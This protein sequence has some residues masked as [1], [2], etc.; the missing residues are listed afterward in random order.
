MNDRPDF[1]RRL[2][3]AFASYAERAP[4][5]VDA[6]ILTAVVARGPGHRRWSI[7]R[8]S[9]LLVAVGVAVSLILL[10]TIASL[11][12]GH[13]RLVDTP[14]ASP[15]A[16]AVVALASPTAGPTRPL[17][18]VVSNGLIAYSTDGVPPGATDWSTGSDVYVVA[19][20]SQPTLV[21]SREGGTF[22]NMCPTFSP[23]GTRLA[24]AR[25][26]SASSAI[27]VVDVDT[28]GAISGSRE[29]AVSQVPPDICPRWSTDSQRIGFL[30]G[31]DVTVLGLDGR[32]I[33]AGVGDPQPGDFAVGTDGDPLVSPAGDREARL[34][35][36]G[37]PTCRIVVSS[38]IPGS[39]EQPIPYPGCG[40]GLPSWS[41][42]GRRLV[43]LEDV[44]EAFSLNAV[45]VDPSYRFVTIVPRVDVNGERAW[46]GIGDIS[47]Q[48]VYR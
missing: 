14:P 34:R 3:A 4:V 43:V 7:G 40:Y 38:T 8:R 9:S 41:P 19:E 18:G 42:D 47:W 22:R 31:S 17:A 30:S 44:G 20:G 23:D 26:S 28:S 15:S 16:S 12:G 11:G 35:V 5:E 36:V 45:D 21:G 1:E 37:N 32:T 6:A 27:V 24:F 29:L 10:A 2:T 46:P 25:R 48:P 13:R 33:P 39:A